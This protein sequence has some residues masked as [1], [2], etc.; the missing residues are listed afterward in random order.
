M[1]SYHKRPSPEQQV[2]SSAIVSDF[3]AGFT[4]C[5]GSNESAL[6]EIQ[7]NELVEQNESGFQVQAAST[8]S[9]VSSASYVSHV[10]DSVMPS[11]QSFSAGQ[12]H[13]CIFNIKY[14]SS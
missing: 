11:G 13:N 4:H 6:M 9:Q 7:Q 12:F 3:V 10:E 5:Q 2:Q 1:E 8:S 14:C